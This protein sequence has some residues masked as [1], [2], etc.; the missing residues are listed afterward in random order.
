[1]K[2]HYPRQPQNHYPTPPSPFPC[3]HNLS[4]CLSE[5]LLILW[6]CQLQ[7]SAYGSSGCYRLCTFMDLTCTNS[8]PKFQGKELDVAEQWIVL[9]SVTWCRVYR[10]V[11]YSPTLQRHLSKKCNRR[12]SNTSIKNNTKTKMPR[13]RTCCILKILSRT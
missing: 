9:H 4:P 5:Q 10:W 11:W 3:L 12:R 1:M 2:S 6:W 7:P 8:N 13:S